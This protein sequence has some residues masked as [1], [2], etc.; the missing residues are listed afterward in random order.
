ML[1]QEQEASARSPVK[2]ALDAL[3]PLAQREE[4]THPKADEPEVHSLGECAGDPAGIWSLPGT[5][6][7]PFSAPL[8]FRESFCES[9]EGVRLP[10][11]RG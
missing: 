4:A 10:G 7:P 2:Q 5:Q 3:L 8:F 6:S 1:G 9:G 11:E